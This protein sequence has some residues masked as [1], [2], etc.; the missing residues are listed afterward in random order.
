M[1]IR[2]SRQLVIIGLAL[3]EEKK[4]DVESACT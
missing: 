4:C 1:R 3:E 2:F